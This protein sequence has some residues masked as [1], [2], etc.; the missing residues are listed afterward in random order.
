MNTPLPTRFLGL[1]L[2]QARDYSALVV[3][4][5]VIPPPVTVEVLRTQDLWC[6]GMPI[7][8]PQIVQRPE[9]HVRNIHRFPLGTPYP[10]IV[11][12]V[13]GGKQTP[14]FASAPLVVDATGV[15][16]PV[17]DMFRDAGLQP[18]PIT[19]VS[20]VTVSQVDGYWHVPKRDL[21]SSIA[22]QLQ[23]ERLKFA[24][25]LQMT[26]VLTQELLNFKVKI[27]EAA[28][29]TYGAWRERDHDDLVLATAL[30]IWYAEHVPQKVHDDHPVTSFYQAF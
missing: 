7:A 11:A 18:I 5:R 15:G 21:V 24:E 9:Y 10:Q 30:V 29:D 25:A 28:N 6:D 17:V 19:I 27:T 22:V 12:T 8:P 13:R 14:E 20:G 4:E 3:I 26:E 1:D 16:R 23:N 2:G